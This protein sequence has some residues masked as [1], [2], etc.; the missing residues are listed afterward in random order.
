VKAL[1][2]NNAEKS[3]PSDETKDC[4]SYVWQ[5]SLPE[6]YMAK[7]LTTLYLDL[8]LIERLNKLSAETRVPRAVYIRDAIDLVLKKYEKA[9]QEG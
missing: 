1:F 6:G 7:K 5:L 9:I 8:E 2:S 4:I 3:K